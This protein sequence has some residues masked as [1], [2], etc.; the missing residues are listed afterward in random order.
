M[1][2]VAILKVLEK[3]FDD[4]FYRD[5][6]RVVDMIGGPSAF[7]SKGDSVVI[8]P[9]WWWLRTLGTK[10]YKDMP[11]STTDRRLV[12]AAASMFSEMGCRVKFLWGSS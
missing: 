7:A 12:V 1:D 9:N 11:F 4:E 2:K 10:E 8:K 6:R 5:V 3:P